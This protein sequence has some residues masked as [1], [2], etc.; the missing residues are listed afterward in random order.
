MVSVKMEEGSSTVEADLIASLRAE[1]DDLKG[2]NTFLNRRNKELEEIA[3]ALAEGPDY[4]SLS[5]LG[6]SSRRDDAAAGSS[7][8]G[9]TLDAPGSGQAQGQTPSGGPHI[10]VKCASCEKENPVGVVYR[11]L[12]CSGEFVLLEILPSNFDELFCIIQRIYPLFNMH[13][14]TG[15]SHKAYAFAYVLA[16]SRTLLR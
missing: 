2:Q 16:G 12:Q 9:R 8:S 15:S 3:R 6:Q 11:C 7:S 5:F 4:S 14:N 10:G 13:G 1:N